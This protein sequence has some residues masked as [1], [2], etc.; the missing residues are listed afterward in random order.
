MILEYQDFVEEQGFFV[1]HR[2]VWQS[3]GKKITRRGY[4]RSKQGEENLEKA[5]VQL[6][7]TD[8]E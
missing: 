4:G 2:I 6:Y 5:Q 8:L 1:L 3:T 7:A